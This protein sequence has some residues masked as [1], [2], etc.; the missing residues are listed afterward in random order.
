MS[1][2]EELASRGSSLTEAIV[3]EIAERT[4]VKPIDLPPLYSVVDPD[5]LETLARREKPCRVA[6]EYAGHEV[7][8]AGPERVTVQ[9]AE[10]RTGGADRKAA[11]TNFP[12]NE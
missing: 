1:D 4:G 9:E 10:P 12:V 11:S 7:T 2:S 6:F 3:V 8:V 5:A